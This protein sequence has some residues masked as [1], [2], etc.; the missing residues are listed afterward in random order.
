MIQRRKPLQRN[1]KPLKRSPIRRGP[2][3]VRRFKKTIQLE[4]EAK[5]RAEDRAT[6]KAREICRYKT[7][8]RAEGCCER[9]G[10]SLVLRPSDARH[11][12]EIANVHEE[13]PRSLG[14][15]PLD[16]S[17]TVCLCCHCHELVTQGKIEIEWKDPAR[18][19]YGGARFFDIKPAKE[20]VPHGT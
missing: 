5:E 17:I 1:R 11:E 15:D 3:K 12:F 9:C 19:A 4:R 6:A 13:P 20:G 10:R 18:K 16:P 7:F 2:A 14:G 8:M